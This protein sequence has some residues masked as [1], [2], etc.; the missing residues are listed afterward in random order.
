VALDRAGIVKVAPFPGPAVAAKPLES[1]R[2]C[3]KYATRQ[4]KRLAAL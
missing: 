3:C 4:G 1:D 2:E